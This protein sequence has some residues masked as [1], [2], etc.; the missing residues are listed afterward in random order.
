MELTKK[1]IEFILENVIDLEIKVILPEP[2]ED[3]KA[4]FWKLGPRIAKDITLEVI[5][6][7]TRS[8][9]F[10]IKFDK[11]EIEQLFFIPIES[12][13]MSIR[14]K[15]EKKLSNLVYNTFIEDGRRDEIKQMYQDRRKNFAIR[16]ETNE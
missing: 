1:Y 4:A 9:K 12:S 2:R 11:Y 13:P 8:V 5:E 7:Y 6:K 3:G 14:E 15:L 10:K 16:F